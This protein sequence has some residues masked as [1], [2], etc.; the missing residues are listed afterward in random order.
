MR[1]LKLGGVIGVSSPDW[2]GFILAPPSVALT[3]AV[4]AYRTLQTRNG[5]DVSVGCKLGPHLAAGGFEN[6]QMSARYEVY[7]SLPLIG[8]YLALQL[9]RTGGAASAAT[10]RDCSRQ[11]GGLF[12]QC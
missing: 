5:S 9:D 8:D 3:A 12:A 2:D 10:L 4:T 6:C 7:S 1:V 11:S